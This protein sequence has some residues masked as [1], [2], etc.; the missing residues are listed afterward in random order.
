[1][2]LPPQG[3]SVFGTS[4]QFRGQSV[5]GGGR[6][7]FPPYHGGFMGDS[8]LAGN[9]SIG[10]DSRSTRPEMRLF[11]PHENGRGASDS[12]R[13]HAERGSEDFA[14]LLPRN[15]GELQS[16]LGSPDSF[17]IR[18]AQPQK[19]FLR[20]ATICGDSSP[21]Q[22]SLLCLRHPDCK[23]SG[24]PSAT[25]QFSWPRNPGGL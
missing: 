4:N 10:P 15:P 21:S 16:H 5:M 22:K 18:A 7:D 24:L 13:S 25:L 20:K 8:C 23:Q 11:S 2:P 1:L 12:V 14:V 3:R 17:A 9:L 6:N 19:V